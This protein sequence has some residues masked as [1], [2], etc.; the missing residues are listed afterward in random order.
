FVLD[1]VRVASEIRADEVAVLRTPQWCVL[2]SQLEISD[3][4]GFAIADEPV[5]G[6][7]AIV[8]F[9]HDADVIVDRVCILQSLARTNELRNAIR[10]EA[11]ELRDRSFRDHDSR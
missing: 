8:S 5:V 11:E 2:E 4:I 7:T 3:F 1:E 6:I 10:I 9:F